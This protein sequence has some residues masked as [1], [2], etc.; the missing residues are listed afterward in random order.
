MRDPSKGVTLGQ[1]FGALLHTTG[2][3]VVALA[4]THKRTPI[5]VAIET[6]RESQNGS[7]GYFWG[8]PSYVIDHDGTQHQ[9]APDNILTAHAGG[10]NREAYLSGHWTAKCSGATLTAWRK[11]W[12]TYQH[13]YSLFPSTSP[14]HDYVGIEMIPIG[15]GFGGSPMRPGLLFTK[16]QH[17]SAAELAKDIAMRWGFP[18]GWAQTSRLLGHEDVDIL[19]RMDSM[20]GWDP[21][22]LRGQPYFDFAFVRGR[23]G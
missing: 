18:A 5:D 21:G 16:E 7:N 17:E 20:G 12:P 15:C 22:W 14:N 2:R 23:I 13:P 9:L 10:G 6:Y 3:G 1:R 4:Q 11:A 19:N 8:G